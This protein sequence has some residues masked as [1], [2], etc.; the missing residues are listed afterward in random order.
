MLL[1]NCVTGRDIKING[2]PV[3]ASVCSDRCV[4]VAINITQ[5]LFASSPLFTLHVYTVILSCLCTCAFAITLVESHGVRLASGFIALQ[6]LCVFAQSMRVEP[7]SSFALPSVITHI[8]LEH[9]FCMAKKIDLSWVGVRQCYI[10]L[11][12]LISGLYDHRY[13][14][15]ITKCTSDAF[16]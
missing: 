14:Y 8:G 16:E 12:A 2:N 11:Q 4:I 9:K 1:R 10:Y 6:P 13:Q 3:M 5:Q 7:G 15:M